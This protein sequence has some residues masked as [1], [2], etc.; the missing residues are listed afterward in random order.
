ME[1]EFYKQVDLNEA[2]RK[3]GVDPELIDF[4]FRYWLLRRKANMN[5]P[6]LAP[7]SIKAELLSGAVTDAANP[8][9]EREK[10]KKFVAL[11]QDLERVRNLCY[12]VSRREKLQRSFVKLREQVGRKITLAHFLYGA[13]LCSDLDHDHVVT[14]RCGGFFSTR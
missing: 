3:V 14:C 6:L 1:C 2:S 12:M 11:R 7:R 4:V 8:E 5:K 9:S 10:M 13:V